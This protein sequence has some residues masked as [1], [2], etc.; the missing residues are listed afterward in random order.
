[1]I[2]IR[3]KYACYQSYHVLFWFSLLSHD[4]GDIRFLSIMQIS[5]L[6]GATNPK[7]SFITKKDNFIF[8]GNYNVWMSYYNIETLSLVPKQVVVSRS[9]VVKHHLG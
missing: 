5:F 4:C 8:N 7:I 1:M 9:H 2:K 3:V 6:L